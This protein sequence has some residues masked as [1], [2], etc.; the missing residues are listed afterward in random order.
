MTDLDSSFG[1]F[2]DGDRPAAP[3]CALDPV[4]CGEVRIASDASD[5]SAPSRVPTSRVDVIVGARPNF[6]KVAPIIAEVVRRRS[7]GGI[8]RHRLVH[9]GQHYDHMM[10]GG[11]FDQLGI[12]TPDVNLEVG[13]GTQAEQSAGIMIG[14]ERLLL[15]ERSDLCLVVGDVN[16]T[17]ACAITAKKCGLPVAHVEAG[18]RSGDWGMPEEVN[19][20]V[21]DSV[22]DM[23]FTTSELA[24]RNLEQCGAESS[25]IYFVGNTMIDTLL[26][27]IDRLRPPAL[28]EGGGAA[29]RSLLRA[30]APPA[31]E[32]RFDGGTYRTAR[33]RRDCCQGR[34]GR[35]PGSPK[36]RKGSQGTR[37]TAPA[38]PCSRAP[39]LPRVQLPGEARQGSD[40][41]LGRRDRGS[42]RHGR[43]LHDAAHHDRTP[44][45]GDDRHERVAWRR[46]C[47]LATRG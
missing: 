35:V 32:R 46:S 43:P 41:R 7:L 20:V 22:A 14:Y 45:D 37:R 16:S 3:R 29:S 34:A 36:D 13:S 2:T 26:A 19:R 17:M 27:N 6:M 11:F 23:F 5:R 28:L 30:D 25:R 24:G 39:A 9:T 1:R 18:I 12:P 4:A 8:V 40:H 31:V 21:T 42:N 15:R 38:D 44:G 47:R 33:G 10:S